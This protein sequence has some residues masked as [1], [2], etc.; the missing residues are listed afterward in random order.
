MEIDTIFTDELINTSIDLLSDQQVNSRKLY[1]SPVHS[2]VLITGLDVA[3]VG[4]TRNFARKLR[5]SLRLD[6]DRIIS[7]T[8]V[9][10][11]K[12]DDIYTS[13]WI[14]VEFYDI[15]IWYKNIMQSCI[16]IRF[17][18]LKIDFKKSTNVAYEYD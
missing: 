17:I 7:D 1:A 8:T 9:R 6:S 15:N 10:L 3:A 12:V 2:G 4:N 16:P 5:S 14:K 11:L 18:Y 13:I